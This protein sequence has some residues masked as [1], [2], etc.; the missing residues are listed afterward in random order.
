MAVDFPPFASPLFA[1]SLAPQWDRP[2]PPPLVNPVSQAAGTSSG[3]GGARAQSR[4]RRREFD[5][6]HE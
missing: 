2:V 4:H 1:A 5:H 6:G 3:H